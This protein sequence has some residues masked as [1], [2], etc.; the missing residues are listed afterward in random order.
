MKPFRIFY[1]RGWV[2]LGLSLTLGLTACQRTLT[3]T[4]QLTQPTDIPVNT[5]ITPDPALEST[6][7]PY[8]TQ[9]DQTMNQV[10]GQATAALVKGEIE[11]PLGNFVADL[12]RT[13]TAAVYGKPIDM[14]GMT[15]GGL[16][17]PID[18]G[19]IT[20]GDVFELMPFE[21]EML[22]L[23]LSGQTVKELFDFAARTGIL[24]V[25]NASYTLRNGQI[26]SIF[27]GG[28]P[29]DINQTY[30]LAISDYLANGGDNMGFLKNALKVEQTGL[31][32]RDAIMNEIK[33]RTAQGKP[34]TTELDGRVKVL[35]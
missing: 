3:P 25:S 23:T 21:N 33:Q 8:R 32:A 5:Q 4:A 6:I 1:S 22:V 13:Q 16:R 14:G 12:S 26:G 35:N 30:T 10:I 15:N 9:V 11:S 2:T 27:I 34:V 18:Q 31:L 20:V 17:N 29:F 28:K 7:A 24:T 19:P